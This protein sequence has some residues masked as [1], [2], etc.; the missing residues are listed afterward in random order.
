MDSTYSSHDFDIYS[1][2]PRPRTDSGVSTT[3]GLLQSLQLTATTSFETASY[4]TSRP[5]S[6][7][8]LASPAYPSSRLSHSPGYLSTRLPQHQD[9]FPS[10][11][12]EPTVSGA[13]WFEPDQSRTQGAPLLRL[14]PAKDE[15]GA[16]ASS[17]PIPST[18][19]EAMSTVALS[20]D[21][22]FN[23]GTRPSF[24]WPGTPRRIDFRPQ[25]CEFAC[26]PVVTVMDSGTGLLPPELGPYG[27]DASFTPSSESRSVTASPPRTT[28]TAEQREL[29]RQRDQARHNSKLQARGRRTDSA[30]SSVYSPPM[31][32][33]DLTTGASSMPVYTTAP[34]QIS[35]LTEPSA[36]Q[37]LPPFSP[38]LQD[39]N[40]ASMFN[41]HYP[42]QSYLPDYGY[43]PSTGP[44]LPSHY[45]YV[46]GRRQPSKS[47]ILTLCSR[48]LVPE[49]NLGMYPVAP[50]IPQGPS[51]TAGQ[52][53]VVHSRPKP[54][55]W[56]HGCN[57]R[58]FSTFSNLLRHQREKSGQAAK[59]TCPNCGA[60]FTRTTARNG[61]L[62][63]DKCKKKNA[64]N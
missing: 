33:A 39:Q 32:I 61:H 62:L 17:P 10:L 54:Q 45:G 20:Y 18:E 38:P 6:S 1:R 47:L 21:P 7:R 34:S 41:S 11:P 43:P 25:S 30:S 27:S 59:A 2:T 55:C 23:M 9:S 4:T 12:S 57:G 64:G 14:E 52:V 28:L 3:E 35:L 40:Q 42:S 63:H 19:T 26:L 46:T 48:P 37:Y 51:D 58:Q 53:R 29:K 13:G 50:V 31:T 15:L 8:G 49:P 16:S 24:A 56:E 44:S 60:E 22:A 36:P 5:S